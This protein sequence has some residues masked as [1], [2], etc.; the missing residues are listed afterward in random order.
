MKNCLFYPAM[1]ILSACPPPPPNIYCQI[2]L[3]LTLVLARTESLLLCVR[4]RY[5]SLLLATRGRSSLSSSSN[6]M[7]RNVSKLWSSRSEE[8]FGALNF[9]FWH[10]NSCRVLSSTVCALCRFN[11][12][13]LDRK[14]SPLWCHSHTLFLIGNTGWVIGNT[15][16]LW[17]SSWTLSFFFVFVRIELHTQSSM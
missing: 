17:C 15:L 6:L 12:K 1:M 14:S 8:I 4:F 10:W 5:N 11:I 2:P 3:G 16:N 13:P 7:D 9:W